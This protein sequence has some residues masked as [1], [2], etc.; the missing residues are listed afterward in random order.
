M[1]WLT[2]LPSGK[3]AERETTTGQRKAT[4]AAVFRSKAPITELHSAIRCLPAPSAHKPLQPGTG[5]RAAQSQTKE[6]KRTRPPRSP[7]WPHQRRQPPLL[8]GTVPLPAHKS[9]H[10]PLLLQRTPRSRRDPA[11]NKARLS[12][13]TSCLRERGPGALRARCDG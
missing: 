6:G 8:P 4:D 2:L 10:P 5:A 11:A 12:C 1:Q 3:V 13:R 9:A 7:W